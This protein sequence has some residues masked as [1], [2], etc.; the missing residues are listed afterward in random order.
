MLYMWYHIPKVTYLR[1]VQ[2]Q[3]FSIFCLKTE[4][5]FYKNC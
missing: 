2:V 1:L 5:L 3:A 4:S